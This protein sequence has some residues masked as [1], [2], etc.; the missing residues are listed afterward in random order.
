MRRRGFTLIEL[1]VVIAIIAVLIALLLPAVQAAREAAR[2]AQCT[3][4]LKQIGLALHNYHQRN[5]CFPRAISWRRRGDISLVNN[6]AFSVHAR[7]L[8]F[9]EQAAALQRDQFL[10]VQ[11][12]R[13]DAAAQH[14]GDRDAADPVSSAPPTLRPPGTRSTGPASPPGTTTRVDGLEPRVHGRHDRRPAQRS[15]LLPGDDRAPV[16]LANIQDGSSNTI[17]FAEWRVGDGN[18]SLFTIPTDIV[19]LPSLPAG[20]TRNTATMSMPAGSSAI[21]TFLRPAARTSPLPPIAAHGS[22][23]WARAGPTP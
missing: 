10:G 11:R 12:E 7:L 5:D 3:N 14:D 21:N 20:L 6:G 15:V 17:A 16:G 23:R 13:F 22:R 18:A 2:R 4:N 9:A 19:S 8:G 1:L